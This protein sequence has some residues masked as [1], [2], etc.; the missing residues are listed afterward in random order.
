MSENLYGH[1]YLQLLSKLSRRTPLEVIWWA[2]SKNEP[3]APNGSP[4][5]RLIFPLIRWAL[6]S[7]QSAETSGGVTLRLPISTGTV[8]VELE[9]AA[10]E[11]DVGISKLIGDR[12]TQYVYPLLDWWWPDPPEGY[13]DP[14][15]YFFLSRMP[16]TGPRR[17]LTT[18]EPSI[19]DLYSIY[20]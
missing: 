17:E 9:A 20:R 10:T 4:W 6:W 1:L 15:A 8:H 16:K 7:L 12:D 14:N 13:I 3:P 5:E 11:A 2:L 19:K 18:Y